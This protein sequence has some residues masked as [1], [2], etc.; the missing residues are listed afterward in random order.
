MKEDK[1]IVGSLVLGIVDIH[2][3]GRPV[4][5]RFEADDHHLA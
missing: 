1:V 5:E 2:D 4:L 3:L